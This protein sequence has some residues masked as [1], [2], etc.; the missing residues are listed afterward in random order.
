MVAEETNPSDSAGCVQYG[1]GCGASLFA[2]LVVFIAI[3]VPYSTSLGFG[4]VLFVPFFLGIPAVILGIG[5]SKLGMEADAMRALGIVGKYLLGFSV[6]CVVSAVAVTLRPGGFSAEDRVP[7]EGGIM[8]P[9]TIEKS[10][11]RM[12]IEVEQ[13]IE[14]GRGNRYQRWSFA[15]VELLDENKE[16]LA[17]FGGEFWHYAGYDDGHWEEE[18]DYYDATLRVPSKGTYFLRVQTE[19][20]VGVSELSSVRI[21]LNEQAWWGDPAPLQAAAFVAFFLGV[22]GLIISAQVSTSAVGSTLALDLEEGTHVR[23]RG[24]AY[25]VRGRAAYVYDEWRSEEWTLHSLEP[26]TKRPR[27]LEREYETDSN[28]EAWFWSV[29]V[30]LDRLE[31]TDVGDVDTNV[32]AYAETHR[33]LPEEVIYEGTRF[34]LS[35]SGIAQRNNTSLTYHTYEASGDAG[36]SVTLEGEP[37]EDL[38]AVVTES[39]RA[40]EFE[41][42]TDDVP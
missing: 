12:G 23:F 29:P 19:S 35:D 11:I 42:E 16:Y 21:E 25:A 36:R 13:N 37:P 6:L 32:G 41:V 31:C 7:P 5:A 9:V 20:N 39:V 24:Q 30:H 15:T 18:D 4:E 22:V 3:A 1:C 40:S 14:P 28:W 26:G 10:G 33:A 38:S 8:G 27:Y 17:S 2:L 34:R